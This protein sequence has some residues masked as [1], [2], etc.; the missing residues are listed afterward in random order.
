MSPEKLALVLMIGGALL[1][2]AV[3]AD[4]RMMM[5][6][7]NP[8]TRPQILKVVPPPPP[9]KIVKKAETV[10]LELSATMVSE[11][12]PMVI[13]DGELLA[14]GDSIKGLKLIEVMEGKA[15]FA[16]AGKQLTF[17]IDEY[18]R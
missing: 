10:D 15:V 2:S 6:R 7:N 12:T 4:T 8:F 1:A 5:L 17:T 18:Q 14:I 3:I 13:V 11:T 9:P 16:A